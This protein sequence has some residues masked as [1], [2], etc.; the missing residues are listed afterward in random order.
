VFN[1]IGPANA[2]GDYSHAEGRETIAAGVNSHVQGAYNL[3]DNGNRYAH[4]VGNGKH[5][6]RSNAHT[7]DWEGNAWFQGEV[8][9]G[10]NS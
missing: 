4:I 9:V 10:G 8:Y 7:L 1:G 5:G 2:S 3:K 6:N